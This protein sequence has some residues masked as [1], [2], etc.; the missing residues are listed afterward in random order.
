MD[1]RWGPER[2]ARYWIDIWN[3]NTRGSKVYVPLTAST[4]PHLFVDS[5]EREYIPFCG[6]G[7]IRPS[8]DQKRSV[9]LNIPLERRAKRRWART[10][11]NAGR[12]AMDIDRRLI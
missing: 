9:T 10:K 5:D 12:V 3:E 2:Y 4:S 6:N 7:R 8:F 11:P 1:N